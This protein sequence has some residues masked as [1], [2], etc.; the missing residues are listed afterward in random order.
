MSNNITS[1]NLINK[2]PNTLRIIF[3]ERPHL[4]NP[5]IKFLTNKS[6]YNLQHLATIFKDLNITAFFRNK[7]YHSAAYMILNNIYK[8]LLENNLI[9]KEDIKRNLT[10]N[11][12]NNKGSLNAADLLII[13]ASKNE[14][15]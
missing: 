8:P 2:N 4:I 10:Y 12:K 13:L 7:K 11:R 1:N 14:Q 6:D 3:N 5:I 9:S 15:Y